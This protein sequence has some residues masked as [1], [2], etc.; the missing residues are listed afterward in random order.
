[1]ALSICETQ[2][3]VSPTIR[4]FAAA[5]ACAAGIAQAQTDESPAKASTSI[6]LLDPAPITLTGRFQAPA[7]PTTFERAMRYLENEIDLK[8][9]APEP[10]LSV[11]SLWTGS[12][13]RFIPVRPPGY[14]GPMKPLRE[15][16]EDLMLL[17]WHLDREV[18]IADK[19]AKWF[20][21]H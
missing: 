7:A 15:Q 6:L 18:A 13:L 1:M 10:K 8:R 9:S 17:T 5:I 14:P 19:R 11:D 16:D 12:F 20:F 2:N 21:G 4:I 3:V